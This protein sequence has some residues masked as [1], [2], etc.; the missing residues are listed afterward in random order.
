M[1]IE[2]N[3][4]VSLTYRLTSLS[5]DLLEEAAGDAP[6]EYLHGGYDGIFPKVEAA[7]EGKDA[8]VELDLA[9]EPDDAFGEYDAELVRMEPAHLFPAE[10]HVGMQLEGASEDGHHVMLYTVT[11]IADGKVVVDGNHPLAGQT[12]RLQCKV[13]DVRAASAEEV[14]HGHVHGAH[15]HHHDH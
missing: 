12:L 5:G 2:K 8:G 7:L 13:L 6:A 10:I 14:E 15:G 1:N 9:L 4:V 11:D 3:T